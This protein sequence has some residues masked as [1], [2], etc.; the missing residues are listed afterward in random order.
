MNTSSEFALYVRS[1]SQDDLESYAKRA[2]TTVHYLINF[3]LTGRRGATRSMI[4]SLVKASNGEISQ[5]RVLEH[6]FGGSD[7]ENGDG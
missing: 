6:I 3:L 1:M 4:R 7:S 2:G 5:A